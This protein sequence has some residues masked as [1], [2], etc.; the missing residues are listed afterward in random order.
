MSNHKYLKWVTV[1][2][3][4]EHIRKITNHLY[5]L[6]HGFQSRPYVS[7]KIIKK[8]AVLVWRSAK[9]LELVEGK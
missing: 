2:E 9:R 6:R 7:Y 5:L 1:S 3:R 4:D 8:H